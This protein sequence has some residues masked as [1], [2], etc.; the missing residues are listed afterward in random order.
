MTVMN[1]ETMMMI[2]K[3]TRSHGSS[4]ETPVIAVMLQPTRNKCK[5]TTEKVAGKEMTGSNESR[6]HHWREETFLA[7][8]TSHIAQLAVWI[9]RH[10]LHRVM[11]VPLSYLIQSELARRSA[12]SCLPG[13]TLASPETV[14]DRLR[15]RIA[16]AQRERKDRRCNF[17]FG[18]GSSFCWRRIAD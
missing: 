16:R 18:G 2:L 13:P 17:P 3:S 4:K 12:L 10:R 6:T 15:R 1:K 11:Y 9:I 14:P 5:K 7:G 8:N